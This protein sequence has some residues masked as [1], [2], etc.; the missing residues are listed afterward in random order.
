MEKSNLCEKMGAFAREHIRPCRGL[1]NDKVFPRE[2]WAEMGSWGLLNPEILMDDSPCLGIAQ[3]ARAMVENGGNLGLALSWMIHQMTAVYLVRPNLAC[4]VDAGFWE[5]IRN[6][7]ATVCFA[8]SEP[9]AG[10]HPKYMAARAKKQGSHYLLS[11]EK[12]YLT[13][14]PIAA[15]FVVIAVTGQDPDNGRKSFSAFLVPRDMPG[16]ISGD[17]LEIPFFK[18]SPHGN[19]QLDVCR[20]GEDRL[21]GVEGRAFPDLVLPFRRLEDA[22]MTGAVSGA[23]MFILSRTAQAMGALSPLAP[24]RLDALGALGATTESAV[25]L[26]DRISLLADRGRE[27][28][29]SLG[30]HFRQM[31]ARFLEDLERLLAET[32]MGLEGQAAVLANDLASSARIGSAAAGIRKQKIG[33]RLLDQTAGF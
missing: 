7:E 32:G 2:I 33:R 31:A 29:E 3:T 5:R 12:V 21:L 4:V 8:V 24:E 6:G 15:C 28:V 13:N 30:I 11:G 17:P 16:L 22:A 9:K 10:A 27:P 20:L 14:G 26:S 23:M 1:G 25:Y 18:P 19:I